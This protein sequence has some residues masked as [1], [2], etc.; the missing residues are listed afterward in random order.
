MDGGV[1]YEGIILE[2]EYWQMIIFG[3][4]RIS[5]F[6]YIVFVRLFMIQCMYFYIYV[7]NRNIVQIMWV[8][9]W[10][11]R[12]GEKYDQMFLGKGKFGVNVGQ[13][14]LK[15]FVYMYKI[16]ISKIFFKKILF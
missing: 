5:F 3:K 9:K 15:Y 11:I 2:E 7:Y 10:V 13:L 16:F 8:K 6:R 1:V 4:E 14:W 12:L